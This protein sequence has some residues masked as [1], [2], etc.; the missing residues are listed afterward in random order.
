MVLFVIPLFLS[1]QAPR[2]L[3]PREG[4][5]RKSV[6]DLDSGSP[7]AFAGVARNGILIAVSNYIQMLSEQWNNW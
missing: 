6:M 7:S 5:E 2:S 4:G 3:S 1:G